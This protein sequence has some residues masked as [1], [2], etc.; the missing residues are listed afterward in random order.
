MQQRSVYTAKDGRI[1][2]DAC[3]TFPPLPELKVSFDKVKAESDV[4]K[5]LS[6]AQNSQMSAELVLKRE[7]AGPTIERVS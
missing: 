4:V 1:A 5:A 2:C 6:D 7:A 3:H